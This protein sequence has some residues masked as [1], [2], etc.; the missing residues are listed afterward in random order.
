M[1]DEGRDPVRV[2]QET[3]RRFKAL[4]FFCIIVLLICPFSYWLFEHGH[5]PDARNIVSG[6]QWL[7]RTIFET[8]SAY[9]LH[10]APGFVTYYIVRLAGVSLVA[11]AS[12]TIA[13]RL[14]ATVISKGKGMGK[15]KA[16]GHILVCGWNGKGTEII[17]EL[18]AK[19]VE[20]PRAIVVLADL[21]GSPTKSDSVEFIRGDPSDTDD[22]RRAGAHR[23]STAIIIADETNKTASDF[24]RDARSLLTC[25][26]I[27][28][29]NPDVYTCVE[30]IKS[31]NREHFDR[32]HANEL[33]VSAE[34]TGA[35]LA[36]SAVQHGLSRLVTDLVTH[37]EG[38]EF[39]RL[40]A[41]ADLTGTSFASALAQIKQ[42]YDATLVGFVRDDDRHEVNPPADRMLADGDVLLVITSTL[43]PM[44]AGK[45]NV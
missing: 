22:L 27:E 14:V 34:L 26:A 43:G 3:T 31:A 18:Q 24:D 12:G 36:G 25:L 4:T 8:S 11:F 17:R 35:L 15:T 29:I 32:T 13:S 42:R 33:V 41:P 28:S 9:K 2:W 44:S 37:P 23:A 16:K 7:F 1:A 38:Q 10:T 20:D 40:Q 21:D 5:S 30:V 19:E 45:V 39:Y 6:Y